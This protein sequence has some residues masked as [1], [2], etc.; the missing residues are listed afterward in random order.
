METRSEDK[1]KCGIYCIIN[2]INGKVYVGKSINIYNRIRRHIYDCNMGNLGE[3]RHLMNAWNKYS[4]SAFEYTVLEL[5]PIDEDLV[6]ERELYWMNKTKSHNRDYGYNLRLDTKT[7]MIVTQETRDLMSKNRKQYM[8]DHPERRDQMSKQSTEYFS[9][10]ENRDSV[11]LAV[12]KAKQAVSKFY[13]F[14]R[15]GEFIQEFDTLDDILLTY[16]DYKWQNIYGACNGS[17]P[18]YKNCKWRRVPKNEDIVSY[19]LKDM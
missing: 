19:I 8:I 12:K 15:E 10:Q 18:T 11:A 3:N 9:K 17:K 16:P 7:N 13:Q 4:R 1:G 6:K 5:L 14:T 2:T